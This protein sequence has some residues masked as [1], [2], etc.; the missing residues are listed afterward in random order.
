ML[1]RAWFHIDEIGNEK[2]IPAANAKTKD[3]STNG[4]GVDMLNVR[5][6]QL[7]AVAE[8]LL[9]LNPY[10]VA[11]HP[12]NPF[13]VRLR[14]V[15]RPAEHDNVVELYVAVRQYPSGQFAVR[16]ICQFIDNHVIPGHQ[17]AFH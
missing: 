7:D 1:V 11:G 16:G 12:D 13:D 2:K 15:H 8:H 4:M 5:L 10:P 17:R 6:G 9:A 3:G 14:N